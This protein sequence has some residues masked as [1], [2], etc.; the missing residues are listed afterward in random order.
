MSSD[1]T[2]FDR[3][4][5]LVLAAL[6]L[7]FWL[8]PRSLAASEPAVPASAG[9]KV[10]ATEVSSRVEAELEGL[11]ATYEDLHRHPEVSFQEEKT[12]ARVADAL[13][14]AGFEVTRGFGD[15]GIERPCHGVVGVLRNGDG[16]TV[17]VR[18]DLDALPMPE[19]TGL[20]Y[21]S[22]A[23]V[24]NVSG[25]TVPA[26][27]ACGHD[28]HMTCFLGAAKI[29][30]DLRDRWKG[31]VVFIGQPAEE[32][33]AGA[34]ALLAD[35]LYEKFPRPDYAIA[36][37]CSPSVASGSVGLCPG[38]AL[39]NVDSVDIHVT[40]KGGHGA[41]PHLT[42]DPVTTA[43]QIVVSLQTIV[44]RNVSPF[45][46]AVITVGS[47]H[48]GTAH[49]IIP[50]EAHLQLTVRSYK[51]EVREQLLT[52]IREIATQTA[53]GA[54]IP[55]SGISVEVSTTATTPSTYNDPELTSRLRSI[56]ENALGKQHVVEAEPVMA[57]E[58][59]GR[60]T[61]G[62]DVPICMMWLGVVKPE[63][64]AASKNGGPA[65]AP[66]HNSRFAPDAEPSIRTGVTS[67]VSAVLDL[68]GS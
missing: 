62:G 27:H 53:L 66:L 21:A 56:L 20:P 4:R 47:F 26:M 5:G 34:K 9:A 30:S 28:M 38:Y 67:F 63:E 49:N 25:R 45:D 54:G 15:Y 2:R 11:V 36:L 31:T 65:P 35:G 13:R 1:P 40:G 8:G 59:F 58:D 33:G 32:R 44:S 48:A 10:S 12:S 68:L 6:A 7:V 23:M 39:A 42:I 19:K 41:M 16:P 52:R 46:P 18:T 61:V 51:P 50:D 37:H 55:E 22:E 14:A 57:G 64:L 3:T 29:V 43:A 17:L 24:K 60:Y